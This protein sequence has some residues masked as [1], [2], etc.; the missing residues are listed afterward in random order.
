MT[1]ATV[2][3]KDKKQVGLLLAA[4]T[5]GQE[6]VA[7][8][9][10]D[11]DPA[12]RDF[13]SDVVSLVAR[14]FPVMSRQEFIKQLD[15]N[16]SGLITKTPDEAAS[17]IATRAINLLP[18]YPTAT[19][20]DHEINLPRVDYGQAEPTEQQR[21]EL[22]QFLELLSTKMPPASFQASLDEFTKNIPFTDHIYGKNFKYIY[23]D[24]LGW[25][26]ASRPDTQIDDTASERTTPTATFPIKDLVKRKFSSDDEL[27]RV[28]ADMPVK[29]EPDT[30]L[31]KHGPKV[32]EF[33]DLD[34]VVGGPGITD[35]SIVSTSEGRGLDRI[36]EIADKFTNGTMDIAGR[37]T[38]IYVEEV[39]GEYFIGRD[40][41]HRIAAL[42]ALG[43]PF[44]PMMVSHVEL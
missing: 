1:V 11:L 38:P 32:A 16:D 6:P 33:V 7:T 12:V 27:K 13:A 3:D 44:A 14:R 17:E 10:T 18:D 42:K 29:P 25:L 19:K 8:Y 26:A 34:K 15:E 39:N 35:W 22:Q 23:T 24:A 37:D 36:K 5:V 40:G 4:K 43:V 41:R 28:L 2:F 21:T 30:R 31:A 20:L 9:I